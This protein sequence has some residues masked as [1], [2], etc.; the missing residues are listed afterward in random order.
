MIEIALENKKKKLLLQ[1]TN[2]NRVNYLI[3]PQKSI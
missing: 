1:Q 3:I 2:K